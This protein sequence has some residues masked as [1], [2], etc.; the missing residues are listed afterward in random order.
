MREPISDDC[1]GKGQFWQFACHQRQVQSRE[2]QGVIEFSGPNLCTQIGRRTQQDFDARLGRLRRR[3]G[4]CVD[5]QKAPQGVREPARIG[6]QFAQQ[7]D[8]AGRETGFLLQLASG[9]V[10]RRFSGLN[11][12]RGQLQRRPFHCRPVLSN[13]DKFLPGCQPDRRHIVQ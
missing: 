12:A 8:A 9:G 3:D 13:E 1:V 4:H 10:G 2:M 11:V 7:L 6:S 5:G